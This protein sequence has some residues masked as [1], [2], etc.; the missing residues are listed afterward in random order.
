MNIVPMAY[1]MDIY[2]M[3]QYSPMIFPGR[4]HC[5]RDRLGGV[6]GGEGGEV[7]GVQNIIYIYTPFGKLT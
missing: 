7:E 4:W 3:S 1:S 6:E 5:G 2:M